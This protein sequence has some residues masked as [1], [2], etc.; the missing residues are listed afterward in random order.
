MRAWIVV[1]G[2]LLGVLCLFGNRYVPF[3]F[4]AIVIILGLALIVGSLIVGVAWYF[5]KG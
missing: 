2:F 3:P 5:W 1:V 4:N